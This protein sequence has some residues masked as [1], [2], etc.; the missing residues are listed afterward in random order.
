MRRS[1]GFRLNLP[2]LLRIPSTFPELVRVSTPFDG[3][4]IKL[5]G[6]SSHYQF[7]RAVE[8]VGTGTGRCG[9]VFPLRAARQ[10]VD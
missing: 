7:R 9:K 6:W 10:A 4:G 3:R 5:I 8:R 1:A 2:C